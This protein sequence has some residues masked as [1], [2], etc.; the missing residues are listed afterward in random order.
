MPKKTTPFQTFARI[1]A[2]STDHRAAQGDREN[3]KRKVDAW[4]KRHGKTSAD[5]PAILLQAAADEA[6]SQPPP[7]PSDPRDVDPS[8]PVGANV[9][10]LDLIRAM[11][12]DYLALAADQYVACAL[13]T[14]HTHIYDRYMVTPR[15]WLTSPVRGCGKTVALDMLSRLVA[16]P[17][18]A[19]NITAA[20]IYDTIDRE[21]GTML[22]DEVDNLELGAKAALRSVLNAGYRKGRKIVRGVG[23]QRREYDVFAPIAL[24]SIGVLSLPLISR[25][26]IVRMRRH[27]GSRVLKRFDLG[28]TRA[29]D[30]TYQHIRAWARD[31][32]LDPNPALP[33]E[34]RGRD[35]DNW[36]PLI[37]IADACSPAWGALA[38]AAAV[39]FAQ[40]R[41]EEDV[42]VLLLRDIRVVFDARGIDRITG[43][44]LLVALHELE[45]GDWLEFCGAKNDRLSHKLR[46]SELRALLRLFDIEPRSIWAAGPRKP[47]DSSAKG[48]YRSDFVAAW[49]AY[50]SDEAGTPAQAPTLRLV[51][52]G[53][54]DDQ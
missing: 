27:D 15:L 10:A 33:R 20:A 32:K 35:A 11:A 7:P 8:Q 52:E 47:G 42:G 48:Y 6:A 43:K 31:V 30:L 5:I 13:W 21:H 2:V 54:E 14:A 25:S 22:L 41:K 50:C 51:G 17:T 16:R 28:D 23:K 24:A 40:D 44:A 9:T 29:L 38:R 46:N 45:S 36:R 18:L 19:D 1:F 4:L 37:A 12:E 3:A 49:D 39:A 53:G 26:I 34:L